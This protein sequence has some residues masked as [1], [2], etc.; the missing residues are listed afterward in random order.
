MRPSNVQPSS[1]SS[2]NN[3][4]NKSAFNRTQTC[5]RNIFFFL[6]MLTAAPPS[7]LNSFNISTSHPH[8]RR[9]SKETSTSPTGGF[10][11]A[12]LTSALL[13]TVRPTQTRWL[14]G[15]KV[16]R[17]NNPS[18]FFLVA[19]S[20]RPPPPSSVQRSW[21][22]KRACV[23]VRGKGRGAS[24]DPL[25][26]AYF[27]GERLT[28]PSVRVWKQISSAYLS[29]SARV[30]VPPLPPLPP[31][32]ALRSVAFLGGRGVQPCACVCDC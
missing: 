28:P 23:C 30:R 3:N 15:A 21:G 9:R 19:R 1:S 20:F 31:P 13:G 29:L 8:A 27:S 17:L 32:V 11:K 26:R 10:R 7:K 6:K 25:R 14:T 12:V 5:G 22:K 16:G 18:C 24:L 2:T 4:N